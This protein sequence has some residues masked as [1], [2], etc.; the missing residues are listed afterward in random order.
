[1]S[2]TTTWENQEHTIILMHYQ[3]P[4]TWSE[5]EAAQAEQ[6]RLINSVAHP[7]D[8]IM[9]IST[10]G[11]VPPNALSRFREASKN[12]P[13]NQR[14]MVFV[15]AKLFDKTMVNTVQKTI[16]TQFREVAIEFVDTLDEAKAFL[17][18]AANH[19]QP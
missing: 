14:G 11:N 13:A 1:M 2:I 4:W 9:D 19:Q 17:K 15:G 16:S 18:Q 7:V 8:V 12:R 10:G 6:L 3:N 5:F